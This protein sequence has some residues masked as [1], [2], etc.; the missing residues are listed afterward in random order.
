M[1]L[2]SFSHSQ[3]KILFLCGITAIYLA[4]VAWLDFLQGPPWWDEVNFWK[5]SLIFSDSLLPSLSDLREYHSLNTPLPFMI[6]GFLEYL[7]NQ[8]MVAGRWLNLILSLGIVAIIGWPSR[9]KGGRAIVCLI[10]L[11]LCPYFLFLSGRLY[12]EMITCTWVLL[13]FMAYVRNR[14]WAS[15]LAFVLAISS[16]Q[17]MLAFP[18]AIATYEILRLANQYRQGQPVSPLQH[19]RWLAPALASLSFLGWVALFDG[20]APASAIVSH[21][22]PVQKSTLDLTPGVAIN[23]LS[24]VGAYIV[25]PEWLLFRP[26]APLQALRNNRVKWLLI[27]TGL[28]VVCLIFP[29]LDTPYGNMDKIAERLPFY[30]LELAMY[31]GL[32]LIT[33][34]RFAKLDL[35]FWLVV[36]NALIMMK[37]IPWDRYT[38]PLVVAFWYLKSI[39]YSESVD[40]AVPSD[41]SPEFR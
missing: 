24:F 30:G 37:A 23:F 33:C 28:L 41:L 40:A 9:Q 35:L 21:A 7:F 11:F 38:L 2:Q 5:S 29:P 18:M 20:L 12:T 34:L 3:Q 10:G 39:H 22:P 6:F 13:G 4:I 36:F 19:Q 32:A 15:C 27:A 8:G 26:A 16:R 1:K 31:Y 17:Y 14:H 25:I